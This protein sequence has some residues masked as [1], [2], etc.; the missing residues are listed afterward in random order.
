MTTCIRFLNKSTGLICFL[1]RTK[2]EGGY[3]PYRIPLSLTHVL[4]GLGIMN[5]WRGRGGTS[6]IKWYIKQVLRR[7]LGYGDRGDSVYVLVPQY[8]VD[9]LTLY[10]KAFYTT[11]SLLS[12]YPYIYNNT[13][14][15]NNLS[16]KN[17]GYRLGIH[18]H[19][20]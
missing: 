18:L 17:G 15:N 3:Y 14:K 16:T 1:N 8:Q 10:K 11:I 20:P 4:F 6:P 19:P 5:G 7:D 13:N 12:P 2:L 9:L